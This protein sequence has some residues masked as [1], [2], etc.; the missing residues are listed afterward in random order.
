KELTYAL[1]GFGNV[2]SFFATIAQKDQPGW[3]LVAASDSAGGLHSAKGL[4][5]AELEQFKKDGEK[6]KDYPGSA[7]KISNQDL[8]ALEVDVLVLAA[9][10][11]SVTDKNMKDVK[12]RYVVELANGPVSDEAY[13]YLNGEG[14][15]VLPDIIANA[16]GVI[17]SYLEWLQNKND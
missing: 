13:K 8:L 1:E 3:K 11:D 9:L 7:D 6:F 17:V 10:G 14:V 4:D 2:G 15:V 5:A 16:G 12:A